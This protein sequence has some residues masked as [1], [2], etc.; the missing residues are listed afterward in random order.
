MAIY[1]NSRYLNTTMYKRLSLGISI[2]RVR[3]RYTFNAKKCTM[4]EWCEGDTLDGIAH[5]FYGATALRWAILDA[6][7]Q[8][9]TPFD[10]KNGDVIYIPNYDEVVE[11]VNVK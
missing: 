10:I 7:P 4:Y 8:Y 1:Q 11:L 5:K 6:N 2:L 3:N 9:R